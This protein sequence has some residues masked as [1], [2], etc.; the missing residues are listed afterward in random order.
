MTR[1]KAWRTAWFGLGSVV[2]AVLTLAPLYWMVVTSLKGQFNLGQFPPSALPKPLTLLNYQQIFT[3]YHFQVYLMNSL[4]VSVST[5]LLVLFLGSL[6]G[7]A[8]GRLPVR[9]KTAI[10]VGLLMISVFPEIAVISPLYML[11]RTL[12]WLNSYQALIIPYT[13]F[14]LPFAIWI[15]RN[16]FLA[17]PREMEEVARMDGASGLRTVFQIILPQST[18]GLFTAGVFTFTAAWTEFLMALTFNSAPRFRTIP[19]GIALFGAQ[20]VIPYGLIF[21][22]ST[23]AVLPIAVGVL[24]FRRAVVSGLTQGAVKG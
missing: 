8:L 16:Y 10:M 18:P 15:L 14:N 22:A 1:R 9:G 20:F 3:V 11:M 2:I 13:A 24:V 7:Y 19:V 5:T 4:V 6:A 23:I 17:I 21:A 12:G